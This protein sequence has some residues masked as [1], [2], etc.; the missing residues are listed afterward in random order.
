MY[1]QRIAVCDTARMYARKH[2][3]LLARTRTYA[4]KHIMTKCVCV[5]L[6]GHFC[7]ARIDFARAV[8]WAV[9]EGV[10]SNPQ[11]AGGAGCAADAHLVSWWHPLQS[12]DISFGFGR[13]DRYSEQEGGEEEGVGG[14]ANNK[15]KNSCLNFAIGPN[16]VKAAA[17]LCVGRGG[18]PNLTI[19]PA[20]EGGLVLFLV[21]SID[22]LKSV[23]DQLKARGRDARA[24]AKKERQKEE[25]DKQQRCHVPIDAATPPTL[26]RTSP[27]K[28]ARSTLSDPPSASAST[29]PAPAPA[30]S[31][32]PLPPPATPASASPPCALIWLHGLGD[33]GEQG[34]WRSKFPKLNARLGESLVRQH[35]TAPIMQ[36]ITAQPDGSGKDG[37]G[38]HSWFDIHTMPVG[39]KEPQDESGGW[40]AICGMW[41]AV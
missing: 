24:L 27:T 12:F 26:S 14:G 15:N 37:N 41:H 13:D 8:R 7:A 32:S 36:Q 2:V 33:T 25:D 20:P 16:T 3:H 30:P 40:Y 21:A 39:L 35:P 19:L 11:A 17:N 5:C 34:V 10:P 38:T 28:A 23:A 1:P 18:Q 29:P 9:K 6:H 31:S 22:V 4:C